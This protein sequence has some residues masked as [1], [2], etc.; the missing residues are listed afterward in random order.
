MRDLYGL[1]QTRTRR[2]FRLLVEAILAAF[3]VTV[4]QTAAE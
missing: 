4:E 3:E 2:Q 1:S